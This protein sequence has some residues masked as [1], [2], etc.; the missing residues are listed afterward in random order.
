MR[1]LFIIFFFLIIGIAPLK[2]ATVEEV[3]SIFPE[4]RALC[5]AALKKCEF[6][7]IEF[8]FPNAFNHFGTITIMSGA[9]NNLTKDEVRA[10]LY[11]EVAHSILNH[12]QRSLD[13]I[14]GFRATYG[15]E[16]TPDELQVMKHRFEKDADLVAMAMLHWMRKPLVL[17]DAILK[18]GA[19]AGTKQSSTHP[20]V[21]DRVNSLRRMQEVYGWSKY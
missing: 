19:I 1:K 2:A 7:A 8:N 13:I 3:T 20:S 16:P 14:N 15:R 5:A 17:D 21:Q 4:G 10:V 18:L 6:R 12:S 9:Y 11:H